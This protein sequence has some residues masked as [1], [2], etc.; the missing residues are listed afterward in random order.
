M[1]ELEYKKAIWFNRVVI[2]LLVLSLISNIHL[3]VS[4]SKMST[5]PA[6]LA[7][8]YTK[9]LLGYL[10]GLEELLDSANEKNW[11]DAAQLWFIYSNI[12]SARLRA[13][14]II[15]LAPLLSQ[16]QS[17]TIIC[18]GLPDLWPDLDQAA[19]DFANAAANR[20]RGS[21]VDT[22]RLEQFRE[23][24]KRGRFPD[25][26]TFTWQRLGS[27]IDRYFNKEY[28]PQDSE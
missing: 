18:S 2:V 24:I 12:R 3:V 4:R 1:R 14:S 13:T 23:K 8:G 6:K 16:N 27:S 25:Q 20:A 11:A 10:N 22:K 5:Y 15:D 17:R 19:N 26:E 28:N 9:V 7:Q 21:S